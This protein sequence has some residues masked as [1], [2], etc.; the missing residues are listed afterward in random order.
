MKVSVVIPVYNEVDNIRPLAFE[1][2]T[3]LKDVTHEII[4]VDDGSIDNT[5]NQILK[6]AKELKQIRLLIHNKCLG[7]SAAMRSGIMK[8]KSDII[9]TLD[10]DGQNDPSDFIPL[11]KKL[12]EAK[13][14]FVLSAGIRLKRQDIFSKRLASK[15]AKVIRNTILGDTHPDSGCGI[16]VFDKNLYLMMPY[17]NH[18]HRFLTVLAY[19]QG[20]K[21]IGVPVNHRERLSGKSKYTN[22]GRAIV[23]IFDI[24]GVI[25][26]L[27]RTPKNYL[28]KETDLKKK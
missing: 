9:A 6:V 1:I 12:E 8:A 5:Q 27:R 7:Q 26:L 22:L 11:I 18:M 28:V 21:V 4:F 15:I 17:F 3:A 14:G 2:A 19:G 25:W 23:G 13:P 10:G 24:I 20:A 16:R